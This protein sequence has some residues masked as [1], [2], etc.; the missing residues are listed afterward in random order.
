MVTRSSGSG[1]AVVAVVDVNSRRTSGRS[2]LQLC[3]LGPPRRRRQPGVPGEPGGPAR[4]T[5]WVVWSTAGASHIGHTQPHHADSV[6]APSALYT[7]P[8]CVLAG[9]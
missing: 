2:T 1:A 5:G 3:P 6:A 9:A 8:G 4:W 7:A